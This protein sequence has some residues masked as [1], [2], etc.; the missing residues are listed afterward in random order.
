MS[1][2]ETNTA[3]EPAIIVVFGITGDLAQRKLLP[4]LYHLFKDKLVHEHT[5]IVGLS[6]QDLQVDDLLQ[7]VE[8]CVLEQDNVCDP[9][10][11]RAIRSHLRMLQIDPANADDYGR[12]LESLN[13]I[14][15][16]HGVC[17]NRL[18]YLSVP[19]SVYGA[20]V[21]NLGEHGLN[22]SC[23][24]G[25]AATRLLVEKPFGYDEAS[26]KELITHTERYFSEEQIFRI[27]HYLAKESAQ[28]ILTFRRHNPVFASIWDG[29]HI[30]RINIVAHEKIGVEG[31]G[32][33]Y[34]DVGALRDLVQS[35]LLQ[36]LAL[37]MCDLSG[38][39]DD[40]ALHDAKQK[41]LASL[42]PIDPS[43]TVRAQYE[44]YKQE[45]ENENSHTESFVRLQLASSL[46]QWEGT[47]VAIETGKALES[48][49]TEIEVVFDDSKGSLNELT[50]RIQP[51]EGID[52]QL[53]AKK[54]GFTQKMQRVRM[55]F[56][57][58]G[59]FDE[60]SH[61]DAYERVLVD[62]A[63]GDHSLFATSDEVIA[64]WQALQPILDYWRTTDGLKIYS[65]GSEGPV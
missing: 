3:L 55:D 44:G 56:S 43:T 14:E 23:Q 54:P 27:D 12:L 21:Q 8:L 33:F 31:R 7:K 53:T 2:H 65:P 10:V 30:T 9:E 47:T 46:P 34:D 52:L 37:V 19:P 11:M 58:H 25:T 20:V 13:A 15:T 61:P 42:R 50:F 24:H 18:Y 60:P 16:E 62:A 45:V 63:A 59:V 28:N 48:K 17:M 29:K 32:G 1:D 49:K 36:L 64:S 5:E 39:E 22:T 51:N 26:G 6:R 57:Y 35:H 4:A 40:I 38:N 41:L